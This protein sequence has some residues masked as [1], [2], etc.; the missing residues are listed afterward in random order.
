MLLNLIYI[1]YGACSVLGVKQAELLFLVAIVLYPNS[2]LGERRMKE[3]QV[4]VGASVKSKWEIPDS[5]LMMSFA[6]CKEDEE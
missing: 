3:L 4:C 2:G 5:I 1:I 6:M